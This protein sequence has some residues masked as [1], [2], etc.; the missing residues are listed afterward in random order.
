[1]RTSLRYAL[2]TLLVLLTG[3]GCKLF[4]QAIENALPREQATTLP[5]APPTATENATPPQ[6]NDLIP[7]PPAAAGAC[8][9][10]FYPLVPGYQWIYALN[11]GDET[12]R[13]S[14]TVA[15]V[16][17]NQA[18]IQALYLDSGVTT[19]TTVECRDGAILNFPM[20]LLGFIFGNAS[21]TLQIQHQDGIFAPA[22]A[23]LTANNWDLSWR[24]EYLASGEFSATIEGDTATGTLNNSP[25][26]MEW[27]TP[28]AGESIFDNV[29]ILAGDYPRAIRL[30][31]DLT[32]DFT[33][34]LQ[35]GGDKVSLAAVLKV[36]N[37]LWFEPN[38]GLLRQEFRNATIQVFGVN[39]PIETPGSVE[40]IEFRNGE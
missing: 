17:G 5:E 30:R 10:T 7:P 9:N 33:A 19:T 20:V 39:F 4:T 6:T 32:F 35:Q 24:G 1:M 8:A 12:S 3:L 38:L 2:L 18:T 36:E 16:Q 27:Q 28:G 11:S 34:E 25:L 22:Y 13:V 14:L 37:D 23:T 40:L 21:G 31:R 26:T 15:E 29:S